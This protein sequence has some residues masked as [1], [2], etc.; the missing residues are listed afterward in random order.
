MPDHTREECQTGEECQ[1]EEC[2]TVWHSRRAKPVENARPSGILGPSGI[3]AVWHS[4]L[5]FSPGHRCGDSETKKL[6]GHP[7][8][9]LLQ[10]QSTDV[11]ASPLSQHLA[12]ALLHL[13]FKLVFIS[14]NLQ[15]QS[16]ILPIA[17]GAAVAKFCV[18]ISSQVR[19]AICMV[20]GRPETDH[21]VERYGVAGR[22]SL[23]DHFWSL[24]ANF[25]HVTS[26]DAVQAFSSPGNMQ[27]VP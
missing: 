9:P 7:T 5:A 26:F 19:H 27:G 20:T 23:S 1:T 15:E 4:R 11:Q 14:S 3:L 16:L 2:Q 21:Q 17:R 10:T 13:L 8:A 24:V 22:T 12:I 18:E 25:R 6:K